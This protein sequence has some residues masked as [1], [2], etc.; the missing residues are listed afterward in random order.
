VRG[1]YRHPLLIHGGVEREQGWTDGVD[2]FAAGRGRPTP[3]EGGP[4]RFCCTRVSG[5]AAPKLA[6]RLLD[7]CYGQEPT[8]G[9]YVTAMQDVNALAEY[10]DL[11]ETHAEAARL[12]ASQ[13]RVPA[14]IRDG[15][16]A[17]S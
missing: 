10:A 5:R 12:R 15:V 14:S 8:V 2:R 9:S 16:T 7:F 11:G 17:Q 3:V 4:G 13:T 1:N 6:E